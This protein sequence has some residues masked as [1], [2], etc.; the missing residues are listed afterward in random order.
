M[1]EITK[2]NDMFAAILQTPN[3]SVFDLAKSNITLENTQLL[4]KDFYK[5]SDVVKSAFSDD[6]G[7]FNDL[8]FNDAYSQAALKF[9]E[10]GNDQQLVKAL[11]WD[12]YDFTAPIESKHFDVR[13][14]IIKDINPY[15]SEYGRTSIDSIDLGKL[16]IKELAQN[17]KVYDIDKKTWSDKSA[18]DLSI[19]D[20]FFGETLTYATYDKDEET[21][22]P[23]TKQTIVHKK[24]DWKTNDEGNFYIET[25][26]NREIYGKQIVNPMDVLT[27]DGSAFNKVDF[28]ESDGKSKSMLATAA[29]LVVEITPFLIPGLQT[30]YGGYK[31]AMGLSYVLPTFYKAI[32]GMLTGDVSAGNETALWKKMNSAQG[33]LAKFNQTSI[34]E[35][36]NS[37]I[38][39]FE[40]LG[41]MVS[42]IYSQIYEQRAA[43][44]LSLLF[45]KTKE[46]EYLDTLKDSAEK[47]L[48]KIGLVDQLTGVVRKDSDYTKIA[49][50]AA[51][52]IQ[53]LSSVNKKRSILAKDLN[54]AYMAMT[55]SADIYGDAL[56]GGYDRRTAGAAALMAASG[57]FA[58]MRNNPLGDWFLDKTVGYEHEKA[59]MTKA[60][61]ELVKTRYKDIQENI[62][63]IATDKVEGKIALGK[64]F[65]NLKS[66]LSNFI[67]ESNTMSTLGGN[68]LRNSVIEGIEEVSEQA[69]VDMSKG[70][71]DFL[72]Y[73]G[74]TPSK[75]SFGGTDVVF[76]ERGFQTYLAN[77]V[78][79]I[80]GGAMF[81]AERTIITP[82]LGGKS[83]SLGTQYSAIDYVSNGKSKEFLETAKKYA[84]SFGST[85]LSPISTDVNG[86][87]MYL[88]AIE[89]LTQAQFI[90]QNVE[91]YIHGVEDFLNSENV[92]QDNDSWVR[93]A[94]IDEVK[95]QDLKRTNSDSFIISDVRVL[96]SQ[97]IATKS[98]IQ[99]LETNKQDIS[100]KTAELKNIK[101]QLDEI[102]SG[103]KAD[104]YYGLSIFTL[105]KGLNSPFVNLDIN[106]YVKNTYSKD[107]NTL[108]KEEQSQKTAEFTSIM[109]DETQFKDKMKAMYA[110]FMKHNETFSKVL[111]DHGKDGYNFLRKNTFNFFKSNNQALATAIK[112]GDITTLKDLWTNMH[113]LNAEGLRT[114]IKNSDLTRDLD[115]NLGKFLLDTK[116][117]ELGLSNAEIATML[118][119]PREEID[120][121]LQAQTILS[122]LQAEGK[123]LNK[124][125]ISDLQ[126]Q[127]I[128]IT[129]D[130]LLPEEKQTLIKNNIQAS[131][132]TLKELLLEE[133][134]ILLNTLVKNNIQTPDLTL[135]KLFKPEV[136]DKVD[137]HKL[138]EEEKGFLTDKI[139]E[140]IPVMD[141]FE[142]DTLAILVNDINIFHIQKGK[143]NITSGLEQADPSNLEEITGLQK[144]FTQH[145]TIK[146]FRV[147]TSKIHFNKAVFVNKNIENFYSVFLQLLADSDVKV[148]TTAGEE[149]LRD[150]LSHQGDISSKEFLEKIFGG[151]TF[152]IDLDSDLLSTLI[153]NLTGAIEVTPDP[154]AFSEL[155]KIF[156]NLLTE[157]RAE[158][159]T[160]GKDPKSFN[161]SDLA[162][163]INTLASDD[164]ALLVK[165][166]FNAVTNEIAKQDPTMVNNIAGQY[167]LYSIPYLNTDAEY[168]NPLA[169]LLIEFSKDTIKNGKIL[170]NEIVEAAKIE[171]EKL[172][173]DNRLVVSDQQKQLGEG[174]T[175]IINYGN[176]QKNQLLDILRKVQL[177][178]F[179]EPG[180]S[181]TMFDVAKNIN[182]QISLEP[183]PTAAK[184]NPHNLELLN[185]ATYT[186][187]MVKAIIVAMTTT[188]DIMNVNTALTTETLYGYNANFNKVHG[189]KGLGTKFG[190][191]SS[192]DIKL[193][194]IE[195]QNL[196]RN[197]THL[198]LLAEN[199]MAGTIQEQEKIKTAILDS[200]LKRVN[201]SK[202]PYQLLKLKHNGRTL[203]SVDVLKDADKILD[204]EEKLIFIENAA[205]NTFISW[206]NEIK[207]GTQEEKIT[208]VLDSIFEVFKANMTIT[209]FHNSLLD[210]PD[211]NLTE[212]MTNLEDKDWYFYLHAILASSSVDFIKIYKKYNEKE[213][214][215]S[216]NYRVPFFTQQFVM[217][218]A[219]GYIS[220]DVGKTVMAHSISFI[221]PKMASD[222]VT[223][224][225]DTS[226]FSTTFKQDIKDS[227]GL[228]LDH[229]YLIRG[230]SGVGKSDVLANFLMWAVTDPDIKLL[231]DK[232][233]KIVLAPTEKTRLIVEKSVTRNLT[234]VGITTHTV[235]DFLDNL[236]PGT[237]ALS[238]RLKAVAEN[239][240]SNTNVAVTD[241]VIQ[242]IP[243]GESVKLDSGIFV[244]DNI[245]IMTDSTLEL[246]FGK[247]NKD[248]PKFVV[249]DE[250][251]K[252]NSL[253]YQILNYL[254]KNKNYYFVV[255]GD[256]L[257]EGTNVGNTTSS[258]EN[259]HIPTSI[260]LKS[261]IRAEN[262][263]QNDNNIA[264]E[265]FANSVKRHWNYGSPYPD[266]TIL[267]YSKDKGV[268]TGGLIVDTLTS[269][270]LKLLDVTKEILFITEDG[271][272]TADQ[273]ALIKDSFG[274]AVFAKIQVS[275]PDV[276]GQEFDQVVIL[277]KLYSLSDKIKDENIHHF[278]TVSAKKA[279]TLLTRA[280]VATII[281]ESN[282]KITN[283]FK[284][285]EHNVSYPKELDLNE[286]K[287]FLDER[288]KQ[289]EELLPKLN[290]E[291]NSFDLEDSIDEELELFSEV[292]NE[293]FEDINFTEEKDEQINL[294]E[295]VKTIL[296][297]DNQAEKELLTT[298]E[299]LKPTSQTPLDLKI[300]SYPFYTNFGK[301]L[302]NF[303][304]GSIKKWASE[305][306]T[307]N[308]EYTDFAAY[309]KQKGKTYTEANIDVVIEFKKDLSDFVKT[310][311]AILAEILKTSSLPA[312]NSNTITKVIDF[313][314]NPFNINIGENTKSGVSIKLFKKDEYSQPYKQ[315]VKSKIITEDLLFLVVD[316]NGLTISLSLL[317]DKETATNPP[318]NTKGDTETLKLIYKSLLESTSKIP[319]NLAGG[320]IKLISGVNSMT[321]GSKTINLDS[322]VASI[323][324]VFSGATVESYGTFRGPYT[325]ID[326][327]LDEDSVNIFIAELQKTLNQY[328]VTPMKVINGVPIKTS[329][330]KIKYKRGNR[331]IPYQ[332]YAFRPYVIISYA[333]GEKN[334]KKLIPLYAEKR[335]LQ[336]FWSELD[337]NLNEHNATNK[338][339]EEAR[340]KKQVEL[341]L[342]RY[343][344]AS[345]YDSW[346]IV[347]EFINSTINDKN[348]KTS[349]KDVI[350]WLAEAFYSS[351]YI[352]KNI[353]SQAI[354]TI[355]KREMLSLNLQNF[356]QE[357]Q[358]NKKLQRIFKSI[359]KSFNPLFYMHSYFHGFS[360]DNTIGD[361]FKQFMD[362]STIPLYY[363]LRIK[364]MNVDTDYGASHGLFDTNFAY[365]YK[366]RYYIQPPHILVDLTSIKNKLLNVP[367]TTEAKVAPD[368]STPLVNKIKSKF[369]IVFN[370]N[371]GPITS[372][373][374]LQVDIQAYPNLMLYFNTITPTNTEEVLLKYWDRLT[375]FTKVTLLQR[376]K[377]SGFEINQDEEDIANLGDKIIIDT[378]QNILNE[379][380]NN[381]STAL[382]YDESPEESICK[383]IK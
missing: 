352:N 292:N 36:G 145:D 283:N 184:I 260:K 44:S 303:D 83:P 55:Q 207:T 305:I 226:T 343:S 338:L 220:G 225:T 237:T 12:P 244:V 284:N 214:S 140:V 13:P 197:F 346:N 328:N 193:L 176:T 59:G 350:D 246:L 247:I 62:T 209:K 344:L 287:V 378:L 39:N 279:Y 93:K 271:T 133:K 30:Y 234:N 359:D 148:A 171:L 238:D 177:E 3:V 309:I 156:V 276:L 75:G 317:A 2:P 297:T 265:F 178:L 342:K 274:E 316:I 304:E 114:D 230:S 373:S 353:D 211:S 123:D 298:E 337:T 37:S 334:F 170:D 336:T 242:Y 146:N 194:E 349:Y 159:S 191:L 188:A 50:A 49:Q 302:P 183:S 107:F 115:I 365:Q 322:D 216:D 172:N 57:Q 267:N 351:T 374:T 120:L 333:E 169:Q 116:V 4:S 52:K 301:K 272:L 370:V 103:E 275:K 262:I 68:M 327:V 310:K 119:V 167:S 320:N 21:I 366:M 354:I 280:K 124:I 196:E 5:S 47:Q 325:N 198:K 239:V 270:I 64:T 363:S 85:V 255:L 23:I 281:V 65:K 149:F 228:S 15:K 296:E 219:L 208:T 61:K 139:N 306:I 240:E 372:E 113:R 141:A 166:D 9:T 249:I 28:L 165:E 60:Y 312:A 218:Q 66:K 286:M 164:I 58:L 254:G 138:S 80:V 86:E 295:E 10:I 323:E 332:W 98:A 31:M 357:I 43:A 335:S 14:T 231:G 369:D 109:N 163:L 81:E 173:L 308:K 117:I 157:V 371:F 128:D 307:S 108:S 266:Q 360:V 147:Y 144:L 106:S 38:F 381:M 105:N 202:D 77:L 92:N 206:V 45:Y 252:L 192:E 248:I 102:S 94:I 143:D 158:W 289:L 382:R 132:S 278:S 285:I 356:E 179:N 290:Y 376:L 69:V 63:K 199:N 153:L 264:L 152:D 154:P 76:S 95:L 224:S 112:G 269:G 200:L 212:T 135:S 7:N 331:E 127:L 168:V 142:K 245:A 345:T 155:A 42:D 137:Y 25:L 282:H 78:G 186:L 19:L 189:K 321:D 347:K 70:V 97:L 261:S 204:K 161:F 293:L 185:K 364:S 22:N 88:G 11:E 315:F 380:N 348:S 329:D 174:L 125:T 160:N 314:G 326:G 53:E 361:N 324:E 96:L 222:I 175:N 217:R 151:L 210:G 72:S 368:L 18:N 134:Q 227:T 205:R 6:K 233:D 1:E 73:A 17:S 319:I 339:S 379:L 67:E 377:R 181:N 87:K 367:P 190:I 229:V 253:Q 32:E 259:L 358:E 256:D 182:K 311:N 341:T 129:N 300:L 89:G 221:V 150:F 110:E 101:N 8:A 104:Y 313:N 232:L 121:N 41:S 277:S 236:L 46:L 29:K 122:R 195:L 79:G 215:L 35:E 20:K 251:S 223:E 136:F 118:N 250:A 99:V 54:L 91:Q 74:L 294:E 235:Q 383:I 257:Q 26:G 131:D 33:Y 318:K 162:M 16:S 258:L 291:V 130:E 375:N 180:V 126:E 241:G 203:I 27:T 362:T 273:I 187:Q 355:F 34:S 71:I 90:Y 263:H 48:G 299:G 268:L 56:A 40:Q 201:D 340:I 51:G 84:D 82:M 24:G 243:T 213:V 100:A 288:Y 111:E 330:G